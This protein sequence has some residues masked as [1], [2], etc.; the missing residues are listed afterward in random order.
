MGQEEARQEDCSV[1]KA[2]GCI[3]ERLAV[4]NLMRA[5]PG[6]AQ[7]PSLFLS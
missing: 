3:S 1:N 6:L 2:L 4:P 7:K 5:N